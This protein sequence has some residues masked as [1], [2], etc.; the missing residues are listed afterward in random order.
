MAFKSISRNSSSRYLTAITNFAGVDYSSQRFKVSST[1]A[2]DLLNFIYKDG[3]I[4]KRNGYEE[5]IEVAPTHYLVY[6]FNEEPIDYNGQNLS[7]NPISG[8]SDLDYKVNTRSF[9]GLWSI[10]GEDKKR[11][12]IA[13]IGHLLYEITNIDKPTRQITP[14]FSTK[15]AVYYE[16]EIYNYAYE[17]LDQKSMGFVG[18]NRFYFLGGNKFMCLR[19][20]ENGYYFYPIENHSETYIPTTTMAITYKNSYVA[21]RES[22]DKVNL[23][24]MWRK[25]ELLSGTLKNEDDKTQTDFYDYTLDSPIITNIDENDNAIV[26]ESKMSSFKITL[27]ERGTIEWS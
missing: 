18:A 9:N 26:E 16:S 22:L 12:V 25:N 14:L 7:A 8:T 23:M 5:L 20:V 1:H 2:I 21:G 24:T 10:I 3:V 4:Q 17:F 6:G 27:T 15:Q 11:H 19:F 13:H